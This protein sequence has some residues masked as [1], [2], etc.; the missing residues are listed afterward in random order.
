M[1]PSNISKLQSIYTQAM[2]RMWKDRKHILSNYFKS[3]GIT[4]IYE[5]MG[6]G[7]ED[8]ITNFSKYCMK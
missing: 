7:Y 2:H 8:S 1:H 4:S 6:N 5:E 3:I